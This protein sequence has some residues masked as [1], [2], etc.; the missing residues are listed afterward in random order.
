MDAYLSRLRSAVAASAQTGSGATGEAIRLAAHDPLGGVAR[1][2][3]SAVD[4]G[5]PVPLIEQAVAHETSGGWLL[6]ELRDASTAPEHQIFTIGQSAIR[7]P[8]VKCYACTVLVP[9][10]L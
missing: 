2:D 8:D 10:P 6:G 9:P 7:Q 4:T 3:Q 5:Q 1:N